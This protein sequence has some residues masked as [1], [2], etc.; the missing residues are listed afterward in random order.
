MN[1]SSEKANERLP[2]VPLRRSTGIEEKLDVYFDFIT[3]ALL[4][5]KLAWHDLLEDVADARYV[6]TAI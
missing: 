3:V 5:L 4:D 2:P 1:D 6:P